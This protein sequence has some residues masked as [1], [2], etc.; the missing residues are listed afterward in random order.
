LVLFAGAGVTLTAVIGAAVSSCNHKDISA[1][2]NSTAPSNTMIS[3]PAKATVSR[4]V[5]PQPSPSSLGAKPPASTGGAVTGASG[6]VLPNP[7]RTLEHVGNAFVMTSQSS[8]DK[9]MASGQQ[10]AVSG[11]TIGIYLFRNVDP[12]GIP[13]A[14]AV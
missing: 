2:H 4:P 7:Q 8:R 12:P 14:S 6:A 13:S 10:V 9:F 11:E 5:V 3:Y 1:Q